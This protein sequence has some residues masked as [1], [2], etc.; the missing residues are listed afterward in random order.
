V[1]F[2]AQVYRVLIASPGDTTAYRNLA[3][4]VMEDWS[5][6]NAEATGVVLMPLIWERDARP[7]WGERT[8]GILNSQLVD[9]ADAAV[10]IF[11]T[12]LG[13]ETGEADSGTVEEIERCVESG[14]PVLLYFSNQPVEPG[15][16][17]PRELERVK[18]FERRIR[19][20]VFYG[21]FTS[22]EE[23]GRKL[24]QHLTRAC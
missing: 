21:T 17:D 6:D 1:A 8:Q 5:A 4:A 15:I 2:P 10:A 19:H 12:M 9:R 3:Q 13:S 20:R 18:D 22:D 16:V 23:F 11:W 14:K 24:Y 7:E